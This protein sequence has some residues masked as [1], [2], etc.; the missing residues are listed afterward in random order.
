MRCGR[1]R[2]GRRGDREDTQP[3]IGCHSRKSFVVRP[4]L[5][6]LGERD[7][8]EQMRIDVADSSTHEPA[9]LD[10]M[11][12]LVMAG[13]GRLRDAGKQAKDVVPIS[14]RAAREL[15]DDERVRDDL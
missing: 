9:F 5:R 7:R 14:E 15:S 13:D 8:R 10:E 12:H 2:F 3:Q 6:A 11:E 1:C 4:E